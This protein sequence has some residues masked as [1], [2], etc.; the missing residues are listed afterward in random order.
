MMIVR[1]I[2]AALASLAM[3]AAPV[4]ATVPRPLGPT[5]AAAPA[6]A[7]AAAGS[8]EGT[9]AAHQLTKQDVDT[10]LDGLMPYGLQRADA[11]GAVVVV[12]KDGQLLTA[13]GYGYADVAHRVRVDPDRTM[14]R[15]G[16]D[17]KLFTW[18]AV[19]QLVQAGKIDLDADINRYLDFKIPPRFGKPITMRDLM[20]HR[21]GFEETL[22][23]L[24]HVDPAGM[25]S[26]RHAVSDWVPTRLYPPGTQPAY[27]NYG[28]TL[29]GYI[30]QRVS[31]EKFDDYIAR[32]ILAPL[33][34]A[35]ST[36][37]Q[38]LPARFRPFMSKG[39]ATA[40]EDPQPFELVDAA[41][42]G[43]FSTTG[44]D[45]ARFMIAHLNQGGPL[46]DP[47]TA[48]LMH[49]QAD[50]P[51]PGLPGMALGFYQES[52]NGLNIIGHGGDTIWFHSDLHLY[53]DKNV[54]LFMA[55]NSRG[56]EDAVYPLRAKLF[57]EFTDRYF[58]APQPQLPTAPTAHAHG[59]AMTGQY[60]SSRRA[61]SS[62]GRLFY[63]PGQ[64]SVSLNPDDTITVSSI[65]DAAGTPIKW[66]EV[67]PWHWQEVGGEKRLGAKVENG[68]VVS[69][70]DDEMAPIMTFLPAP[71]AMN[72]AWIVPAVL[73]SFLV[74]LLTALAWPTIAL[75][76]RRYGQP[77]LLA[78]RPLLLHRLTRGTALL[79][80]VILGIWFSFIE[81][82]SVSLLYLDGR[83]DPWIRVAQILA[84]GAFAG[85]V[86]VC[87][88]AWQVVT[89][90]R[91]WAAKLW[92]VVIALAALFLCW[93]LVVMHLIPT[94]LNY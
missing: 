49:S 9:A 29:A 18:T 59:A 51:I 52:G 54:G 90:K 6:D 32:H 86:V 61:M 68:R 16:S 27:S 58:P 5:P 79:F 81:L 39:Y 91:G 13:R 63:L 15:V 56:K 10:W 77:A 45:M 26:L 84:I 28:C 17:S 87:W 11:A 24:I 71:F 3:L 23:N 75:V 76:R 4:A 30:V 74:M 40:D 42:A 53:L 31:G 60:L 19:M 36:F 21:A 48:R 46:L 7:A 37:V 43:A 41:P 1:R 80:V 88:N 69:F 83:L 35:H 14:F 57:E 62:W 12:V 65:T 85:T 78:G 20:T 73:I 33:G 64:T 82:L 94:S 89:G 50:E 55:F 72:G 22:K 38:P 44:P 34:M 8:A 47:A 92:S 25:R 93:F 66:R 2:A 67:S 70:A